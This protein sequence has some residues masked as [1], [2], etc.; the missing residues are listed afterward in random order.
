[1]IKATQSTSE[2]NFQTDHMMKSS[3]SRMG[4]AVVAH[5]RS[6][7]LKFHQRRADFNRSMGVFVAHPQDQFIPE[8]WQDI[9][10]VCHFG[11][12]CLSAYF[13]HCTRHR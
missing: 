2:F 4:K 7:A 6:K 1:M 8:V 11:F 10:C 13:W 3:G 12:L 5:H 9:V